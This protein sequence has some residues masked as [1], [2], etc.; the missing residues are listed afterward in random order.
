MISQ[1]HR[2]ND[3]MIGIDLMFQ[4]MPGVIISWLRKGADGWV[5]IDCGPGSA[6]DAF[7]TGVAEA[8]LEIG[9]INRIVLTHI[10]L[11]HAGGA[12]LLVQRYPHLRVSVH[13]D[14]APFSID[15]SRLIASATRSYGDAMEQ[16]WGEIV[17]V[18]EASID[19]CVGDDLVPGTHLRAIATPGHAGSHLAYYDT[20][21]DTVFAGDVAHARLQGSDVI[22]PTLSP[23]ELDFDLWHTSAER[24]RGLTPQALA[25]PHGGFFTDVGEHLGGI[26]DRIWNRVGV[27]EE[28]LRSPSDTLVLG[29][30]LLAATRAEYEAEGGDVERKLATMEYCMPSWLG[31]Q[32][33]A[34]WFKVQG[35]FA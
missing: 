33:L 1:V 4:G 34:R 9:D 24:L 31:A 28:I 3:E 20:S 11:D 26:E 12:G 6:V 29:E 8:G 13:P 19:E 17:P 14:A 27:A 18:P 32:G 21:S 22:V 35:R 10:H 7:E 15:P 16:L 30:A 23:I 5:A 2:F 25:L